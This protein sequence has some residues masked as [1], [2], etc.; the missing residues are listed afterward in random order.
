MA[1][2]GLSNQNKSLIFDEI[3]KIW[4]PALPEE[5]V[6]QTL[7]QKMVCKLGFP[8]ELLVIEKNLNQL[9]HLTYN[10]LPQR[11][12]DILCYAKEIHP[13][14]L[15]YPLLL[16]ECKEEEKVDQ[17]AIEQVIGYNEH[18]KAFFVA[19]ATKREE[20][21]GYYDAL[22]NS[23]QFVSFLSPYSHLLDLAKNRKDASAG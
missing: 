4:V 22:K 11:R 10:T 18:V 16:I 21:I 12:I 17:A 15:L 1:I 7:L 9:P 2:M 6:R 20:V 5:L 19:V 23:Y 14:H 13:L 3:R 8:K